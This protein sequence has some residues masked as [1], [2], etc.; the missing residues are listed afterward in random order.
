VAEDRGMNRPATSPAAADSRPGPASTLADLPSHD[1]RLSADALGAEVTAAFDRHADLPGVLVTDGPLVLGLVSRLG[2]FRQM[3]RPFSLEI[4]HRRPVRVLLAALPGRPLRLPAS[5]PIPEAA[6]AALERPV[7]LAYEPVLVEHPA[8]PRVLDAHVLLLAQNRLLAAAN[9]IIVQQKEAA[10]AASRAKS[11]FLANM[12]HEIRTP[13][14]GVLGMT[15]LALATELTA[16]QREYLEMVQA[17]ADSLL[18]IINDILDFSKVEAGKLDLDPVPFRLREAL[19]GLLKPLALRARAKGLR[20]TSQVAADVPDGLIGDP[21]RL[22]QVLINLVGNALKF[23]EQGEV[24]VEVARQEAEGAGMTLRF[25]VRDTG[26]G[27][28]AEKLAV[29]FEPFEQ[30]DGST[31]RKYG[32]TGLGLAISARLVEL[33]GGRL[34]VDSAAGAGSTF[35]FT[36]RFGVAAA[37]PPRPAEVPAAGEGP[38]VRPLRVLLAEDNVINQRLAVRLLEKQGHTAVVATT[39]REALEAL[40]DQA[41]DVVLMDVQMPDLGGLEA[42]AEV[43]A[44]ERGTGR[45]LPVVALTAHAMKGDRERCLAA[46]I[47]D[48]LAKP[49]KP[50]ELAAVLARLL[51]P[52]APAAA[53]REPEALDE[54]AFF[55]GAGADT[56]FL[57]ELVELFLTSSPRLLEQ[58]RDA[59]DRHDGALLGRAAHT[60]KGSL[61]VFCARPAVAAAERLELAAYAGAWEG[62]EGDYAA[63]RLELSRLA[64]ALSRL[65][66]PSSAC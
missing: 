59:I 35:H 5:C 62:V 58:A 40:R 32:G 16:E 38:G 48:Y 21:T 24:A 56:E 31:T 36:A 18:G 64:T 10:E 50:Q 20:L 26:I 7:E 30:A 2:F 43:R 34:G 54:A 22:R 14:N 37:L 47:D 57:P 52:D 27:I 53:G 6:R 29:I 41:F 1:V 61:S 51:P 13:M 8:D 55:A 42:T 33:M 25:R 39:G 60:L 4:F 63:L 65:A 9:Q 49:I 17:S 23:T 28:P 45:R 15:E 19:E 12:S 11:Q 46:G 44:A 3:S 66:A